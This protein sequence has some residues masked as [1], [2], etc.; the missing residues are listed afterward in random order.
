MTT[1]AIP[2]LQPRASQDSMLPAY[3][4]ADTNPPTY[5]GPADI[6]PESLAE[7]N[8]ALTSINLKDNPNLSEDR[9]LAHLK[10]L[11]AFQQLKADVGYTDGLW[12]LFD[13]RA[14]N[15]ETQP[16]HVSEKKGEKG[17]K[18]KAAVDDETSPL[19]KK[20]A[21]IREKRWILFV[22]RAVDRYEA[23][24][25]TFQGKPL[26]EEMMDIDGPHYNSFHTD[27]APMQWTKSMLP[28]LDVLLVWHSHM[29]NPRCYLEDCI[30]AGFGGLWAAGLPWEIINP[31][32]DDTT[33][34][35]SVT[36]DG[37]ANWTS[38]T[39]RSWDNAEDSLEKTIK[40]PICSATN[41][42]PWTTCGMPENESAGAKDDLEGMGFGDGSFFYTC[43]SCSRPITNDHLEVASFVGDFRRLLMD[44]HPMPGTILNYDSG[45]P[46]YLSYS[47]QAYWGTT[48]PNR[49]LKNALRTEILALLDAN[50]PEAGASSIE[51]VRLILQK[52]LTNG[53][54]LKLAGEPS[55]RN[56]RLSRESKVHV[57]KMM[58]RY[59]R[60]Q[61]P[62]A[63]DLAG[64]VHRQGSFVE[65]MYQI[66]WLHSPSARKTMSRLMVKYHR[67]MRLIAE[68]SLHVVVPTLDVDLAWH[69]QQLSP[70]EYMA[71]TLE[72]TEKFI[73]H[74]D[75]I[76][77]L[78]LHDAFSWT[79]KEYQKLYNEVYSECTCWYCEAIRTSHTSSVGRLFGASRSEKV[80]DS[81]YDS[82]QAKLCP[83]D[84][85][86][87]ISAHNSVVI[88]DVDGVK[89]M[90]EERARKKGRRLDK[91]D[92]E[93]HNHWGYGAA[94]AVPF[95]A[96]VVFAGGM[97]YGGSPG[98]CPGGTGAAGGCVAGTCAGAAAAGACAMAAGGCGGGGGT[99]SGGGACGG[100]GGACGG[101]GCGGGGG[102]GCG[103]GGGGS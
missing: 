30:R 90:A 42:V 102:G 26:V 103:G 53:E 18:A 93:V 21:E 98:G 3:R 20:L 52:A 95:G 5:R 91:N 69:T 85:S 77:E 101:G 27:S 67:F 64:A 89:N 7:L 39:G 2:N 63:L 83:P 15:S 16:V 79:C 88:T 14:L 72:K 19:T 49:L 45:L 48:F 100:G 51:T 62:F 50:N 92:S 60:N 84:N 36:S 74:D 57:R 6:S 12:Q 58:A 80:A 31:C 55:S 38:S 41:T 8:A 25:K 81:F 32:I 54:A 70:K 9:C 13:A 28:P 35:Y 34:K 87:H 73:D 4:A 17:E 22:A 76:E 24:W 78:K 44:N 96:P 66:D 47:L 99:C 23:W 68:N 1:T 59:W 40:C 82:G 61:Y 43:A 46:K 97:Y 29:L 86:A 11:S 75:K 10:L 71:F 33:F 94:Y 56:A 37:K 65:K